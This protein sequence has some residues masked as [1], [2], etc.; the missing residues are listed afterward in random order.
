MSVPDLYSDYPETFDQKWFKENYLDNF[1]IQT[2]KDSQNPCSMYWRPYRRFIYDNRP[3]ATRQHAF[4]YEMVRHCRG[5]E[6]DKA[7]LQIMSNSECDP[8]KVTRYA[9]DLVNTEAGTW[10][11]N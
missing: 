4:C 3:L 1:G 8:F 2:I 7:Q 5:L 9:Y 10:N 6:K 11:D